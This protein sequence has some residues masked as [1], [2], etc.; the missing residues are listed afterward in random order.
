M[1]RQI[2]HHLS[3]CALFFIADNLPE[4][5][6][7]GEVHTHLSKSTQEPTKVHLY[8]KAGYTGFAERFMDT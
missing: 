4:T 6:G 2:V 5:V 3:Y 8:P 1:S 7:Q